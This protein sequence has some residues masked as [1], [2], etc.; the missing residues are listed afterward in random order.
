MLVSHAWLREWVRTEAGISELSERLTLG[1]LEVAAVEA[2]GPP[3][4]AKRVIIGRIAACAPHPGRPRLTV[5]EV[6]VGRRARLTIV[7]GA[8]NAAVGDKVPVATAGAQLPMRVVDKRRIGEIESA[9]MICSAAELGL[10]EHSGGVMQLDRDAPVGAPVSDYLGLCDRVMEI[11]LTPNRGDCLGI[12]GVARE[13]SA[14]TGARLAAPPGHAAK[15]RTTSRARLPVELRA[16]RGCPR[17]A[18]RAVR[19]IDLS[20]RTPTWMA[21]RLRRSGVRGVNV[22]VD[23]TNYVMLE[24]GQP[25]HAFDLERL[26]GGIVVRM[27]KAREKLRLLDGNTLILND[28]NLVIADH[29]RA[30]ALAGIMGGWDSAISDS[31]RHIYF[32]SAFFPAPAMLGK[33]RQ[34]GMH[35][36]ASH[37]FERGVDPAMQVRA[38]ERATRLLT[39]IAGGEAGPVTDAC[40]RNLMPR[41]AAVTLERT[42]IPRLLGVSVP[43]Q[44][45]SAILKRLGM[46]V[47]PVKNRSGW[48]VA[49]PTWRS[50][51]S[52]A[53]D[54]VEEIARVVGFDNI[55]PRRPT[56][57][58]TA[59]RRAETRIEAGQIKRTLV[60]RGYFEVITYSFVDPHIQHGLLGRRGTRLSNPIA[61]NMAVMR[62]SL[63]PGLLDAVRGNLNRQHERV[64]LFEAGHVFLGRGGGRKEVHRLAA[65]ATGPALPMQ[66]GEADRAL[67]FF[68]LKG[69]LMALLALPGRSIMAQIKFRPAP[70]PALH[71]GRSAQ[72]RLDGKVLGHLG[73]LHPGHQRLVGIDQAVYLFEID[74]EQ[75]AQAGL[76]NFSAVSRYPAVRRDL[77]VVVEAGVAA[78]DVL[79]T[80]RAAAGPLLTDLEL[81]DIYAGE[82]VEKNH[83][84]FAFRLTFQSKSSNLT[85][86]Q[87]DAKTQQIIKTLQR[88]L[89]ARLRA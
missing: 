12:L 25:M 2:A 41:P 5:C 56:A 76:P 75:L 80:A 10:E 47:T 15:A 30:V 38:M 52:G 85:A 14:L 20:V 4:H 7:C 26:A 33:A 53:H 21:E 23:I 84:S 87:V 24:L 83:K 60:Q 59:G 35:T 43:G 37:R 45:V 44:R 70:H 13:V 46:R 57:T 77:A 32:E 19:N 64:R 69:D 42:E 82:R 3:L 51:V 29:Q 28:R 71:P 89:G 79:D 81:F 49:V 40:A 63:W 55:P 67:D 1:G 39:S 27:A 17:Y 58:A 50:D 88:R 86:S 61:A 74:L 18:G 78:Q 48:R 9:G 66:W 65:A 8:A 36:D 72:I 68:D 16:P 11:E 22:V 31:T 6:D 54:V 34:L 73:Q 62:R